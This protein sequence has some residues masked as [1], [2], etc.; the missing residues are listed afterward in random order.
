M[1]ACQKL[2]NDELV[3][4]YG[5]VSTGEFWQFGKLEGDTFTRHLA[6]YTVDE[7]NKI[8]GA[9][10]YLFAE[11]ERQIKPAENHNDN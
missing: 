10:D 9:L 11:C 4:I 5:I 1:I 3:V 8:L 6:S 2:N 7:P